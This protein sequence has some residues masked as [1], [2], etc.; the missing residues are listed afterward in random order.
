MHGAGS[1]RK[2]D[3]GGFRVGRVEQADRDRVGIRA[4]TA[5]SMPSPATVTPSVSGEPAPVSLK[6]APPGSTDTAPRT[7]CGAAPGDVGRHAVA[8]HLFA[9]PGGRAKAPPADAVPRKRLRRHR[10]ELDAGCDAGGQCG[11]VGVDHGISQA[12]DA[13]HHRDGAVAQGTELG[14]A[15]GFEAGGHQQRVAAWPGS[16]GPGPRRSR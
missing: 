4:C 7:V 6:D 16:D 10:P 12:A 3:S 8:L 2:P 1:G 13:G 9:R 15:A 11:L 14:Q 5:T